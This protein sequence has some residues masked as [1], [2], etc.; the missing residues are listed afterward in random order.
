MRAAS[1]FVCDNA[2]A[3]GAQTGLL[4]G[5]AL[6]LGLAQLVYELHKQE[7]AQ[8]DQQKIDDRLNE[9]AHSNLRRILRFTKGDDQSGEVHTAGNPGN[10]GREQIIDDA[11]D[12]AGECGTDD[13]ADGHVDHISAK[14]EFL[15]LFKQFAR[16]NT[17]PVVFLLGL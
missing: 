9:I 5:R 4:F 13:H 14:C 2:F 15:E 17:P 11:G 10:D 3:E 1:G 8:S 12:D 7:Y 6:Y 16:G